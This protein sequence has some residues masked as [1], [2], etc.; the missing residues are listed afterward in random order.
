MSTADKGLWPGLC[1]TFCLDSQPI[2]FS[3]QPYAFSLTVLS[4][5]CFPV[6]NTLPQSD[7]LTPAPCSLTSHTSV[8][9]HLVHFLLTGPFCYIDDGSPQNRTSYQLYVPTQMFTEGC[10]KAY[11]VSNMYSGMGDG[12]ICSLI[13]DQMKDVCLSV[14]RVRLSWD[15]LGRPSWPWA[16][17]DLHLPPTF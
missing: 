7:R 13:K 5:N 3:T 15:S 2:N 12:S 8:C 6:W 17:T 11:C 4:R 10:I 14:S 9:A 1:L 16:H